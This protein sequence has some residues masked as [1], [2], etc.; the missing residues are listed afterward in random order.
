M[1][2]KEQEEEIVLPELNEKEFLHNEIHKG[3]AVIISYLLGIFIGFLSGYLE[4]I[5]LVFLSYIVG[6]AIAIL[7]PY[8]IRYAKVN[9]DRRTLAYNIIIYLAAWITFWI[10]ALNPPFF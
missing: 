7:V 10:V 3:K 5:G 8:I 9:I 1:A 6:I 2:K 4:Y